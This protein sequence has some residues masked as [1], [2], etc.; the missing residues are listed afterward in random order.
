MTRISKKPVN[1]KLLSKIYKLFYE[2]FSRYEGQ[3]DFFSIIDDILSPTEKIMLSKRLAM[4]YLLIKKVDY[5]DIT[6]TLKVSSATV[7]F[8]SS[9]FYKK[10][11]KVVNIISNML[12][13]EKV[14]YYLD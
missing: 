9:M 6:E 13:K 3:E 4:I 14:L 8:Y 1:E 12:K 10:D 5:R 2:V 7:T 11:S